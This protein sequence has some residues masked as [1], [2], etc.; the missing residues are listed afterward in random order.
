[1]AEFVGHA[2]Q[3]E[4]WRHTEEWRQPQDSLPATAG[5]ADP[6]RSLPQP[7]R[8]NGGHDGASG[9][10]VERRNRHPEETMVCAVEAGGYRG[11]K[12]REGELKA[13]GAN[14]LLKLTRGLLDTYKGIN[15]RY[16]HRQEKRLQASALERGA[17]GARRHNGGYDDEAGD[18][19]I[20]VGDVINNRYQIAIRQGSKSPLLGKGSFGQV[21]YVVDLVEN[22][23]VALKII[24]N[25]KHFHEQA[26]TEIDLLNRFL[27]VPLRSN[28]RNS[29][30]IPE[31]IYNRGKYLP[32]SQWVEHA[33]IVRMLDTF[34][35]RNHQCLVF[36]LLPL[37]LYDLLKF[38]K[39]KGF[40]LTLVRK[41]ARNILHSLAALRAPEVDVIHC[42]LKPE[43]VMLIKANE[44]RIKM[45]DFGS[46]CSSCYKPF[47]Y[48]QSRFYRCPEVLLCRSYSYAIDMW[49]LGCIMAEMH[50]G[51]PLFNG[52]NEYEQMHKICQL[53]GLPPAH[54]ILQAGH[55]SKVKHMFRQRGQG[56]WFMVWPGETIQQTP[57]PRTLGQVIRKPN[58]NESEDIYCELVRSRPGRL[59]MH[60]FLWHGPRAERRTGLQEDLLRQMLSL[61]PDTRIT[62]ETALAHPFFRH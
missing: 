18:Y 24:K 14:P 39:F 44:H 35:F 6:R 53:L 8:A 27:S 23:G 43:N 10:A 1:L 19:I 38:S 56:N 40:S 45:I 29:G 60:F 36:E 5:G 54:M 28:V 46:S 31:S 7:P 59:S 52:K 12:R 9:G 11:V 51:S 30:Q 15:Q 57:G 32:C 49:S 16:Y 21:V 41:L 2:H 22:V 47:T 37:S 25:Q 17:K 26:K 62:P 61:D 20:R 55:K 13:R 48:I 42:D 33:N 58:S 50:T 34:T 4:D 3:E